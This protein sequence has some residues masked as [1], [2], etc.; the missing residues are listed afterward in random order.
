MLSVSIDGEP[1]LIPKPKEHINALT[2]IFL[3][4]VYFLDNELLKCVI[5]GYVRNR[6]DS[7]GVL[8][9][10]K[11][12]CVFWPHDVFNQFNIIFNEVTVALETKIKKHYKVESGE[13][14]KVTN[15]FGRM[16]VFLRDE[17][18]SL[19][20]N[21]AEWHQFTNSLPLIYTALRDNFLIEESVQSAIQTLLNTEEI[22]LPQLPSSIAHR[23]FMEVSLLKRWPNGGG[24]S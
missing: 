11:R 3:K 5:V 10:G 23:L 17:E 20:L 21:Q 24:S 6:N 9:K 12:G 22:D 14:I 13:D 16:H 18:H 4:S 7:L 2:G 15:V 1:A 19:T 8:F